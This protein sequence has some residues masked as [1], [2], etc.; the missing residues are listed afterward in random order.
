MIEVIS[1]DVTVPTGSNVPLQNVTILKGCT[2][3]PQGTSTLML[4]KSGIY[5]VEAFG[6]AISATE[7]TGNVAIQIA[8]NGVLQGIASSETVANATAEHT[9]AIADLVQVSDDNCKCNCRTVPTTVSIVNVGNA[10]ILDLTV[11]VTKV[12]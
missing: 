1:T 12:C 4:N 6:T 7:T 2:V 11:I 9:L 10:A 5:K 3:E 8:K